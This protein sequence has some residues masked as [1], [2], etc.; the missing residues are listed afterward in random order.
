MASIS[1]RTR[2]SKIGTSIAIKEQ[3]AYSGKDI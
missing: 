2:A 1:V 3:H